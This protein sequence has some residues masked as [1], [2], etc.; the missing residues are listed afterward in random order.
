MNGN[1]KDLSGVV[2]KISVFLKELGCADRLIVLYEGFP[3][4]TLNASE[5]DVE[6]YTRLVID[7]ISRVNREKWVKGPGFFTLE[8]SGETINV[9]VL[10]E[11]TFIYTCRNPS[12]AS[13]VNSIITRFLRGNYVRCEKCGRD[14]TLEVYR[15]PRCGKPYPFIMERCPYCGASGF[16]KKCPGCGEYVTVG[17]QIHRE[18]NLPLMINGVVSALV[19]GV[20]GAI[21]YATQIWWFAALGVAEFATMMYILFRTR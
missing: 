16:V 15:C 18:S 14:L 1:S 11:F 2:E 8:A 5:S 13:S 10:G 3:Y 17:G 20:L 4:E 21:S 6:N 9:F 7:I 19:L 12:Y